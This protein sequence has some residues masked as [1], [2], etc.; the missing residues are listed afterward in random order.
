MRPER[1]CHELSVALPPDSIL[2]SDTGHAGIWTGTMVDFHSPRQE[3]IRCAG[4]LGW[5]IPAAV[6]AK[7]AAADRPVV[8]FTGDGGVWYHIA[9]LNTAA[10]NGINVITVVNNNASLNQEQALNERNYGGRTERSDRLWML[11]DTDFA[12]MA[13]SMGCLG[14]TVKHPGEFLSALGQAFDAN[15]PA[16]IDVKTDIEGI[17]PR[18]WD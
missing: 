9:E 12:A 7:C 2:V 6:G 16:L 11:G 1:L 13:E 10:R 18:A 5:G 8:C 17:A 4:S 14:I 15:W 3:Y